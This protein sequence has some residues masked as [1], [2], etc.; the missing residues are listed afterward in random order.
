VKDPLGD[1]APPVETRKAVVG[2]SLMVLALV[3]LVIV[4]PSTAVTVAIIVGLVLTIMLHEWGH[5]IAAKKSGMKVTEFFLG[6]GPRLWS[7][8]RG[9]TEYGIKAIPAGGY[10]RILGMTNLEEIDPEDEARTYRQ[11]TTGRRLVTVLAGIM[12]NLV[13]ALVLVFAV[14]AFHGVPPTDPSTTLQT[15]VKGS[16][17]AAAGLKAGDRILA[18]NGARV[19]SWNSIGTTIRAH[20][21]TPVSI[22]VERA[23]REIT[24]TPTPVREKG[25]PPRIG[26]SPAYVTEHVGFLAAVPRTFTTTGDL[27]GNTVSSLG[28]VFSPSGIERYGRTVT[29]S[30][31]GF[32]DQERP[33]TVIGIV[34]DG[35]SIVDGQWWILL[36]LLAAINIFLAF[37]N[38]LPLPPLDGGHAAVA[39]YE[40]VASRL[41]RRAVR[42]DYQKVLPVAAAVVVVIL[43]FGLSTLYLDLRS[44]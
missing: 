23:G 26:I 16:P 38:A 1:D 33:R 35:G 29:N 5:Y 3:A 28:K 24:V 25:Q 21:G 42:V 4:R 39:L 8:R 11:A 30:Q 36:F 2:I 13:L 44:L 34:A 12:V 37:V 27:V 20:D 7:F 18:V 9:E 10:V 6:F 41:R 40:G 14:V 15:V 19:T 32:S 22:V 31:G 17:A 43:L